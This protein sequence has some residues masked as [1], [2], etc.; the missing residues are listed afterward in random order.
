MPR[1]VVFVFCLMFDLVRLSAQ[2][3]VSDWK[4]SA[5]KLLTMC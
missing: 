5:A 1:Y 3:Q 4:D 2:V